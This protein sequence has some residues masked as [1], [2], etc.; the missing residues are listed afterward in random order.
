[1]ALEIA[2]ALD[3]A[4]FDLWA[5]GIRACLDADGTTARQLHLMVELTRLS[6]MRTIRAQGLDRRIGA[7]LGRLD[8]GLGQIDLPVQPLYSAMRN[9]VDHLEL[10]GGARWIARMRTVVTDPQRSAS[11]RVQ[12]LEAVLQAMEPGAPGFSVGAAELVM[13]V[14]TR[15][16]RHNAAEETAAF[17]AFA[18]TPPKPSRVLP[19]TES[20]AS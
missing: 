11:V 12:R 4:D 10:H 3:A 9:L 7:A 18:L 16:P 5:A 19:R 6:T 15:L 1:M 17:M 2:D 8:I 20:P 13:A 14:T